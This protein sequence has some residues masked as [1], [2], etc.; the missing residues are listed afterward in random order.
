MARQLLKKDEADVLGQAVVIEALYAGEPIAKERLAVGRDAEGVRRIS[1]AIQQGWVVMAIP[2]AR[3]TM[4]LT[5][6]CTPVI[7]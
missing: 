3:L 7:R 2:N 5:Q 6:V 1:T 4:H